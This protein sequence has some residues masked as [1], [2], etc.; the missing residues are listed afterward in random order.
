MG[1]M[2]FLFGTVGDDEVRFIP[3]EIEDARTVATRYVVNKY[4]HYTDRQLDFDRIDELF[5]RHVR[6]FQRGRYDA[7]QSI[8]DEYQERFDDDG[9]DNESE[10]RWKRRLEYELTRSC[11]RSYI[12]VFNEYMNG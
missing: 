3:D 8:I 5:H 7:I 11:M 1:L 6:G 12:R 2:S 4:R 10:D 9:E